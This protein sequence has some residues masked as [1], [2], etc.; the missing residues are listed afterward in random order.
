MVGWNEPVGLDGMGRCVWF[1]GSLR[2]SHSVGWNGSV[3]L[4]GIG[5]CVWVEQ[6]GVFK[7]WNGSV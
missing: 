4:S 2:L 3:L 5:R 6:V 1:N 7:W